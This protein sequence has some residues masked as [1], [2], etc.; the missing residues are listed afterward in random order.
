MRGGP[1]ERPNGRDGPPPGGAGPGQNAATFELSSL[2]GV[3]PTFVFLG[4]R[5]IFIFADP[6]KLQARVRAYVFSLAAALVL[7]FVAAWLIARWIA[8]LRRRRLHAARAAEPARLRSRR[9]DR[10][11]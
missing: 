5:R 7:S 2:L 6:G 3:R 1:P 10:R 9:P 8:A 11:V 4:S